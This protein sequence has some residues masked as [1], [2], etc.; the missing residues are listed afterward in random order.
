MHKPSPEVRGL[1]TKC[2]HIILFHF[3]K[4]FLCKTGVKYTSSAPIHYLQKKIVISIKNDK[5]FIKLVIKN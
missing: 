3:K 4:H 2:L 5:N 1:K